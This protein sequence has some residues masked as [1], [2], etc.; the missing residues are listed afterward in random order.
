MIKN[1]NKRKAYNMPKK[2]KEQGVK[3]DLGKPKLH[4]IP[5]EALELMAH[6][7]EYGM[8]K[9]GKRNY[10]KG[11]AYTRLADAALRHLYKWIHG[12]DKDKESG[13]N[14]IGH[15]LSNLAMLAYMIKHFPDLDDRK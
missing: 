7:F 11:I 6:S 8:H 3:H 4:L 13:L 14:H 9:Y 15:A 5:L 2:I 1:H 10:E 12:Q